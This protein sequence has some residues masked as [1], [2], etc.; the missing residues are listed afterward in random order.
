MSRDDLP[1]R[2][3]YPLGFLART[4]AFSALSCGLGLLILRWV[5]SRDLGVDF[6]PAFYTV[7][8]LLRFLVPALAFSAL[9]V[10]LVASVSVFAVA[11]FAS[12][13]IAGPLFRLQRVAGYL[14]RRILVGAIH[15]RAGDQGKPVAAAINDWVKSRKD[16]FTLLRS[17]AE[18]VE[19]ALRGCEEALVAGDSDR[20]A[21]SL[22]ALRHH[23]RELQHSNA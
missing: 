2:I 13:K 23:A 19:A 14:G 16:R 10:L 18:A 4:A 21:T 7:R 12:H 3:S 11:V 17:E 22:D 8:N 1:F 9:A 5:F 20:F 15:L 6:A